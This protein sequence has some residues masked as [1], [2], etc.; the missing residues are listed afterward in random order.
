MDPE[1]WL[2]DEP[3]ASGMDPQGIATF[4]QET[5]SAVRSRGRVVI[6]ST[7]LV[8]LACGFSDRIGVLSRG[9]LQ[10]FDTERDLGRDPRKLDTLLTAP[11]QPGK[12]QGKA[13]ETP[14]ES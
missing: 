13:G 11:R 3:F 5:E 1:L 4:R 8:D 2:L 10:I 14:R 7:Q 12:G 9:E 6:Y